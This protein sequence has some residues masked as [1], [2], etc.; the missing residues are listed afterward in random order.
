M[1]PSCSGGMKY[2]GDVS[3]YQDTGSV[4]YPVLFLLRQVYSSTKEINQS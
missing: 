3:S 4:H 1:L 2:N